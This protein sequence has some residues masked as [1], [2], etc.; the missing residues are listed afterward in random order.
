MSSYPPVFDTRLAKV[1]ERLSQAT[2]RLAKVQL[3]ADERLA[4]AQKVTNDRLA[5]A[6]LS[7]DKAQAKLDLL[8]SDA[9]SWANDVRHPAERRLRQTALESFLEVAR[10][11]GQRV[12]GEGVHHQ[13]ALVLPSGRRDPAF[14]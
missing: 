3:A 7:V 1:N 6:Q 9:H 14:Q 4:K 12:R 11:R 2:E 5:T 8:F 10:S 13:D